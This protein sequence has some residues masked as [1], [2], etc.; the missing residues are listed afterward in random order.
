[1]HHRIRDAMVFLHAALDEAGAL[2]NPPVGVTAI[3]PLAQAP[4]HGLA[5]WIARNGP[6]HVRAVPPAHLLLLFSASYSHKLWH[7]SA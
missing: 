2:N 4:A 1:M 7:R 3:V 6:T 5:A